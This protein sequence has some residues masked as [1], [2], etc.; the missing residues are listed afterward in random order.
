MAQRPVE[1]SVCWARC[2][3][4]TCVSIGWSRQPRIPKPMHADGTEGATSASCL[5]PARKRTVRC[6][7]CMPLLLAFPAALA[8]LP[9]L[10]KLIGGDRH[11]VASGRAYRLLGAVSVGHVPLSVGHVSLGSRNPCTPTGPRGPR[12]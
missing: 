10:V 11:G 3:L 2:R 8:S 6:H 5:P 9:L 1:R 12:T 7:V 4:V